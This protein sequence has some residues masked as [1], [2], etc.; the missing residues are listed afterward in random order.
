MMMERIFQTVEKT[1]SKSVHNENYIEICRNGAFTEWAVGGTPLK[2]SN[3]KIKQ[4]DSTDSISPP[5]VPTSTN[6]DIVSQVYLHI[7]SS[8]RYENN[9][10]QVYAAAAYIN[11]YYFIYPLLCLLRFSFIHSS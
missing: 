5:V 6:V 9:G 2:I 10:E 8:C 4:S 3:V 11:E 7:L 1:T